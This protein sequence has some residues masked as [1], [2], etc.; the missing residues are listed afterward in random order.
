[1]LCN[2]HHY[3]FPEPFHHPKQTLSI[4][5]AIIAYFIPIWPLP[6]AISNPLS[7]SMNLPILDI[8]HNWNDTVV[9]LLSLAYF[10]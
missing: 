3:L 2:H 10:S 8:S 7:L 6:L 1:M 4:H 9:V 5:E